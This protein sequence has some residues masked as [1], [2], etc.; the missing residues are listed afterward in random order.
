MGRVIH[1]GGGAADILILPE[2]IPHTR[3][4]IVF[5]AADNVINPG[6]YMELRHAANDPATFSFLL[7][8]GQVIVV[9]GAEICSKSWW[10]GRFPAGANTISWICTYKPAETPKVEDDKPSDAPLLN[11]DKKPWWQFRW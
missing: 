2:M 11:G 5:H 1:G 4:R 9:K 8:S 3:I 6:R 7:W 10:V